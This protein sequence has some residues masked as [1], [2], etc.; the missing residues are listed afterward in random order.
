MERARAKQKHK[1]VSITI[2]ERRNVDGE[3][4]VCST[5]SICW[6]N[7]RLRAHHMFRRICGSA[8]YFFEEAVSPHSRTQKALLPSHLED[9]VGN[10]RSEYQTQ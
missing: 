8:G 5:G 6:R 3:R 4:L 9:G 7:P 1:L 10:A 2:L